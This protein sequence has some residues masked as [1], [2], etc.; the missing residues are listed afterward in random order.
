ML[1]TLS[2]R[3][4]ED[5]VAGLERPLH[6]SPPDLAQHRQSSLLTQSSSD[7]DPSDLPLYQKGFTTNEKSVAE[8]DSLED[9]DDA[10]DDED[11]EAL[12]STKKRK[13]SERKRRMNA[14]ADN[15]A[16]EQAQKSLEEDIRS[17]RQN[18]EDQSTRYIVHQA[19]S[20]RIISTP[21]EYQTE[22]FERAKKKNIIAV[23][24]T[25]KST[26]LS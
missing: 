25:G 2:S 26:S 7:P 10:E 18:M 4:T 19:E 1:T 16:Q 11:D 23:L 13:I 9:Y 15:Y 22:L 5:V 8:P 20:Q 17:N 6:L 21:R 3:R 14:I 12:P 24:D